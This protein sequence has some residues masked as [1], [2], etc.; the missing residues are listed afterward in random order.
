M[1]NWPHFDPSYVQGY[2]AALLDVEKAI[3][4]NGGIEEA[5]K[6]GHKR[7]TAPI[8]RKLIKAMIES[9]AILRENPDYSI[10]YNIDKEDFVIRT[11]EGLTTIKDKI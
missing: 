7:L 2:T 4:K 11:K 3:A 6:A 10:Y 9:R 8:L 5:L 1:S